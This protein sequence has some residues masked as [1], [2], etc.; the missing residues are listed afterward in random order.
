MQKKKIII[1][2]KLLFLYSRLQT[3]HIQISTAHETDTLPDT[4]N[5][6]YWLAS[7]FGRWYLYAAVSVPAV[8]TILLLMC[9]A[10][11]IFS[12]SMRRLA[13]SI[14]SQQF[15]HLS[16]QDPYYSE[17]GNLDLLPTLEG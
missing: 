14:I 9:L 7:I 15:V 13:G 1:K 3:K 12:C 10:P 8:L 11:H 17:M 5:P 4:W 6:W 2:Y 16:I